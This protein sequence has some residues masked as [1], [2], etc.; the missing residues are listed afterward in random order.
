MFEI[1]IIAE[2]E[3]ERKDTLAGLLVFERRNEEI[4]GVIFE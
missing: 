4:S 2:Q 1:I 3:R